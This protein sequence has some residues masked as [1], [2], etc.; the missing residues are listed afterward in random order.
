LLKVVTKKWEE[1]EDEIY[2][3]RVIGG[4]KKREKEKTLTPS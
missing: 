4:A 1:I 2:G 3:V